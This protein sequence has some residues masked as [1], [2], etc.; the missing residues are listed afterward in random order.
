MA[1]DTLSLAGKVAI[2]TGSGRENGIGA[3]IALA[4]SRNGAA[5]VINYISEST[6]PRATA[7][8]KSIQAAGGQALVVKA[9]VDTPEG[10]NYLVQETLKGFKTDHIDILGMSIVLPL[11]LL[12]SSDELY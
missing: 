3:A 10:A 11:T 1:P 4:L 12:R 5:V 8:A 2:V 9:N 6:T 7:I